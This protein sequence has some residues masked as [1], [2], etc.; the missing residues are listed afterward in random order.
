[1]SVD[2]LGRIHAAAADLLDRVESVLATQGAPRDHPVWRASRRVGASPEAAVEHFVA[3]DATR[4]YDAAD[5]IRSDAEVLA[6]SASASLRQHDEIAWSG[7]AADSYSAA[8][9]GAASYLADVDDRLRDTA[10][11]VDDVAAWVSRS[12][13]EIAR[14]LAL[15]LSSRQ[16]VTLHT[17]ND[18]EASGAA[19]DVAAHVLTVVGDCV[20]AAWHLHDGWQGQ[21]ANATWKGP[22]GITTPSVGRIEIQ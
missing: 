13:D 5:R 3:L 18:I 17:G 1:V 2:M 4:L 14:S 11:H 21:L 16:A 22:I 20:D 6:V 12:R 7:H 19:A 15:C 8:R 10:Q 9:D